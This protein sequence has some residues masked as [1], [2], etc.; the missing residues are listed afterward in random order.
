[1]GALSNVCIYAFKHFRSWLSKVLETQELISF[2]K[3]DHHWTSCVQ[4][5]NLSECCVRLALMNVWMCSHFCI[6]ML[7][8]SS[9][10]NCYLDRVENMHEIFSLSVKQS[11]VNQSIYSLYVCHINVIT[12]HVILIE[13]TSFWVFLDIS[14]LL[15]VF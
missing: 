1:M 10:F 3:W 6:G 15:L 11:I 12:D 5:S 7:N 9:C 2:K 4:Q 8:P 14:F 13:T